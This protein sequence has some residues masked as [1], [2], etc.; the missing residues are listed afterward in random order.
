MSFINWGSEGPE[1]LKARR[2]MEDQI[3]FEQAAFNAATA[4]AAAASAGGSLDPL[5]GL[6]GVAE[7]GLVYSLGRGEANWSFNYAPFP[8]I[9]QATLNTDDGLVYATVDF[10][11]EVSFVRID[12]TTREIEFIANDISDYTVKG[13]SSLYYEGG[14]N[15]IYLDNYF[16]KA[17][18]SIVRVTLGVN[19]EGPFAYATQV[20]EVDPAETDYILRNLFLYEG[21]TWAIAQSITSDYITGPFN[22]ETGEFTYSNVLLPSPSNPNIISI[23]TVLG[24]VEHKG[25]VYVDAGWLD[26]EDNYSIG[27]FKMDTDNGGAVAPYYLTFVKDL[28]IESAE[29]NAIL[30]ITSF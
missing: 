14:G 25:V 1:Q 16:K 10:E 6:Y 13:A 29:D 20:S 12:R 8:S 17:V 11:G 30:S 2:K 3:M 28:L 21:S 26:P 15:F 4:A 24:T 22:I 7:T 18:S 19:F 9:T 5:R 27:L 23:D